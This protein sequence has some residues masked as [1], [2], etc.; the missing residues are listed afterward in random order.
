[1]KTNLTIIA[2]VVAS[3][4]AIV[5]AR[6]DVYQDAAKYRFGESRANLATIEA[7]IR[8]ASVAHY[9]EI[10]AKLLGALQSSEATADAKRHLVR[11]LGTVGSTKSVPA[12]AALLADEQLSDV[13]RLAL[14]P[15]TDKAAGDA[16]RDAL[17]KAKGR[18]LAGIIGSVGLRRDADAV[19][20]L[21]ALAKDTDAAVASAAI[22]ALGEI[23]SKASAEALA[24]IP[25]A[26]NVA[27]A[28]IACA[29]HLAKDGEK[30]AA[31][32]IFEDLYAASQPPGIRE[33]AIAGLISYSKTGKA[34][35]VF[36]AAA[37]GNDA[38]VRAAAVRVFFKS[39]DADLRKT[40]LEKL[41]TMNAAGQAAL[42]A[43]LDELPDV[44]ARAALLKVIQASQD[45]SLK[46]AALECL[47]THGDSDDVAMLL[48]LATGE[49]KAT[50]DCAKRVLA[51]MRQPG[52]S[53]A[54]AKMLATADAANRELIMNTIIARRSPAA[55]PALLQMARGSDTAA[56]A[57]AVKGIGQIGTAGDVA[58]LVALILTTGDSGVRDGAAG[59]IKLIAGRSQDPKP[60]SDAVIRGLD[61]AKDA[62]AKESLVRALADLPDISVSAKLLDIA[63]A[64][65]EEKL[66]ILALR[67]CVRL[68]NQK[69]AQPDARL[70][71]L[72]SVLDTA[73]RPDEK[74]EAIAGLADVPLPGA[75]DAIQPFLKDGTLAL[76]AATALARLGK[77]LGPMY[78]TRFLAMM[79]EIKAMPAAT[80][81]L[82]Q[83]AD[84]AIRAMNN[85]GQTDGY[86]T[87][88]LL[89]GPFTKAGK[90]GQQLFDEVFDP[91]KAGAPGVAWKA[92]SAVPHR[93]A[94][95]VRLDQL[96]GGGND[97]VAYLRTKIDSEKD[98]EVTLEAGSDDGIKVWLNGQVVI[99][100][101]GVHPCNPGQN[102][103]K[104]NL[105]SGANVLLVKVTQGGGEWEA[106]LRLRGN[107]GGETAGLSVAPSLD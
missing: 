77:D 99:S 63:R 69:E 6:A 11:M 80:D 95:I 70:N 68:A 38:Q 39:T 60:C 30:S 78:R 62:A 12:L 98:Q 104:L 91:E 34:A 106:C 103:A 7:E 93:N 58:G 49:D 50:G 3:L 65:P 82:K 26:V 41:P 87:G 14:E 2:S 88:W 71:L 94:R 72:K 90:G 47:K 42:L 83:T 53:E 51:R 45:Q 57:V 81:A 102:K 75:A 79:Q 28:R 105:K 61:Q 76:D 18:L 107:A 89:A 66:G 32:A 64:S 36:A 5:A 96:T 44:P 73:K 40:I 85:V 48:K 15:M 35:E 46:I 31:L 37:Q 84:E 54:L 56:A 13:A 33:G 43:V 97:R 27:R 8:A 86:L 25:A 92:V 19:K 10:E 29:N 52:A 17:D 74:R 16:L 100:E 24:K 55:M 101:N 1:M 4:F 59:A 20:T 67:G 9:P 21:A 23:G 22:S